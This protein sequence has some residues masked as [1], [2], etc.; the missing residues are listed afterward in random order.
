[1]ADGTGMFKKNQ[2][3]EQV[4]KFQMSLANLRIGIRLTV[5]MARSKKYKDYSTDRLVQEILD[6]LEVN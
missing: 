4:T 1:M 6:M 2:T 3:I 5:K